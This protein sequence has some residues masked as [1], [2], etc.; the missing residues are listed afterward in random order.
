MQDNA[1]RLSLGESTAFRGA[2]GDTAGKLLDCTALALAFRWIDAPRANSGANEMDS[3]VGPDG[4]R[5]AVLVGKPNPLNSNRVGIRLHV[6]D[7]I[8]QDLNERPELQ[9]TFG[10]PVERYLVVVAENNDLR[11]E[12]APEVSLSAEDSARFLAVLSEVVRANAP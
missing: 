11:I 9:R 2:Q 6:L 4:R 7:K 5:D 10:V 8:L 3:T 12:S 1:W